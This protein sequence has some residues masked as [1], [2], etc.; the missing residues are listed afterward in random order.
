MADL[1][2]P[3]TAAFLQRCEQ[4]IAWH[5]LARSIAHLF[6]EH[7]Q[8]GRPF[9]PAVTMLKCVMLQK[10]FALSDPQLDTFARYCG[11]TRNAL[12]FALMS[13]AYNF[14]R[15]FH[16]LGQPLTPARTG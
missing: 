3:R 8:G 14:K 10:W 11:L 12:D 16:L 6:P 1:G 4:L 5:E 9:W 13:I 7:R 15:S 2:G